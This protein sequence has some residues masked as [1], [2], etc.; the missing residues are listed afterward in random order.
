MTNTK[1]ELCYVIVPGAAPGRRIGIVKR[2]ERGYYAA[3]A[4]VATAS[5]DLVREVVDDL[6][7][8]LGVDK[9]EARAMLCGSMFGWDVPAANSDHMRDAQA[10][11]AAIA[12]QYAKA[13]G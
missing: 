11:A 7:A 6:N 1:P 4:D 12:A 2:G 9:I 8:R 10:E 13:R 3:D 5:D